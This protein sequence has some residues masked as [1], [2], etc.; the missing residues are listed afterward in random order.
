MKWLK[1][2]Y[3]NI[4]LI[5][6]NILFI[7]LAINDAYQLINRDLPFI[8]FTIT[9]GI[10]IYCIF[11]FVLSRAKDKKLVVFLL[12]ILLIG[13]TLFFKKNIGEFI[14]EGIIK[15]IDTINRFLIEER[16]V[17]FV[18]FKNIFAVFIPLIA[19]AI[20]WLST[21]GRMDY[22]LIV[23][24]GILTFLWSLGYT[25]TIEKNVIPFIILVGLTLGVNNHNQFIKKVGNM[26]IRH[27]VRP[28][29]IVIPVLVITIIAAFMTSNIPYSHQGK[30]YT[31]FIQRFKD[32]FITSNSPGGN[33]SGDRKFSLKSSGYNDSSTTLGGSITINHQ[34]VL[35]VKSE[36]PL[37]LK[38][39]SKDI[40]DGSTWDAT[41]GNGI[42][43][44]YFYVDNEASFLDISNQPVT[45]IH[46]I[47]I[48]PLNS[49]RNLF[50]P[51]NTASIESDR[52]IYVNDRT[53]TAY[54]DNFN[55]DEYGIEYNEYAMPN[56]GVFEKSEYDQALV[57]ETYSEELQLYQ[58]ITER[59]RNLVE[60]LTEGTSTDME[61]VNAIKGYISDN[62]TYSLNVSPIPEGQDF[63]DY[64]LFE[65]PRG[66]CVYS[67]SAVTIMLR[68]AGIP[69]R[70][71][72]GFK[73]SESS[74][75]DGVYTVTNADAHA[76]TEAYIFDGI[77][78]RWI[79]VDASTTP[80]ELQ[81]EQ[82]NN[83]GGNNNTDNP[84]TP[85]GNGNNTPGQGS[86]VDPGIENPAIEEE[87]S[88]E[89]GD[90]NGVPAVL[91]YSLIAILGIA[92]LG[93]VFYKI[94]IKLYIINS[95]SNK[96]LYG[97]FIKRLR[98]HGYKKD[99]GMTDREFIQSLD[100]KDIIGAM[101]KL[102]DMVY[103]EHYGGLSVKADKKEL[104]KEIEGSIRKTYGKSFRYY[105]FKYLL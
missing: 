64:Y 8:F 105:L 91:I 33:G 97:Y 72:E 89:K 63:V 16:P 73:T 48:K 54:F 53:K 42:K 3:I 1:K 100:K 80:A 17:D 49:Y 104:Y 7:A 59:T 11:N 43:R 31:D 50:V 38:G 88:Q 86:V 37:Y 87:A 10:A 32:I 67:A 22:I 46:R 52:V 57:A 92:L 98:R 69:A 77:S 6:V 61:I 36:E 85:E 30:Y 26:R 14:Y 84:N 93:R 18:H 62:Y 40:Y 56:N 19:F 103:A 2:N 4:I 44:N 34:E 94:I 5:Y 27:G 71:V 102:L 15:E 82:D 76:W 20:M 55:E 78:Y 45:D 68:I 90:S 83:E 39:S 75:E 21:K 65:S 96:A 12:L 23:D 35:E 95:G 9:G 66:Y 101:S 58:G 70:Y 81:E 24:L 41:F 51:I 25:G 47:S 99:K 79:T 29:R 60:E 74:Y 13:T 28:I